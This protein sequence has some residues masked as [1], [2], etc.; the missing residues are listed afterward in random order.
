MFDTVL[1]AGGS[2]RVLVPLEGIK[3]FLADNSEARPSTVI[4][5]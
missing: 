2:F 4:R 1:A 5:K 3:F